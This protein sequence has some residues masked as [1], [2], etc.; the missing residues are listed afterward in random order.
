MSQLTLEN[1]DTP[2]VVIVD[3]ANAF[4]LKSGDSEILIPIDNFQIVSL[5]KKTLYRISFIKIMKTYQK[6]IFANNSQIQEAL[7]YGYS[8]ADSSTNSNYLLIDLQHKLFV[9]CSAGKVLKINGSPYLASGSIVQSLQ[10]SVSDIV[11]DAGTTSV[12]AFTA[13]TLIVVFIVIIIALALVVGSIITAIFQRNN[14]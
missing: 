9:S 12:Y 10:S 2:T 4:C 7:E 5:D 14:I 1:I 8:D 13:I 11:P 3:R 6:V